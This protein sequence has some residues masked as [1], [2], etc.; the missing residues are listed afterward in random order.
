MPEILHR[1]ADEP[2]VVIHTPFLHNAEPPLVCQT[3]IARWGTCVRV[4]ILAG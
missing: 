1:I 3:L 2:P 4:I